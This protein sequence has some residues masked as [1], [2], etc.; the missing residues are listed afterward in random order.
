[1]AAGLRGTMRVRVR[2]T[3]CMAVVMIVLPAMSVRVGGLLAVAAFFHAGP[4]NH[5]LSFDTI[6]QAALFSLT[7]AS[8][9]GWAFSVALGIVF[10]LGMMTTDGVNGLYIAN[11]LGRAD[12]RALIASRVMGL[13]VAGL[14]F[15][16]GTMGLA[17]Y[18]SPVAAAHMEGRELIFGIAVVVI[19]LLSYCIGKRMARTAGEAGT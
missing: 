11:L 5:A 13:A 15:M 9:A 4:G 19:V 16:V 2:M 8:I 12:Q 6:S 18:F 7:A 14:S 10:M 17:K 3:E 1:M